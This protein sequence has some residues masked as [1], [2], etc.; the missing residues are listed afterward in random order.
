MTDFARKMHCEAEAMATDMAKAMNAASPNGWSP[1]VGAGTNVKPFYSPYANFDPEVCDTVVIGVNPSGNPRKPDSI[2]ATYLDDLNKPRGEYN[3]YL[4]E[5]WARLNE[6]GI[7]GLQQGVKAVFRTLYE[8]AT[9]EQK[10]RNA[11]SFNVCPLRTNESQHIPI[12]VWKA[13]VNWC[14]KVLEYLNPKRIICFAVFTPDGKP[15]DRSP[16]HA[17]DCKYQIKPDFCADVERARD[18]FPAFV[19]AGETRS[20][21]FA[22]CEVIGVPHLSYHHC[23]NQVY[24]ALEKYLAQP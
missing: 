7:A 11:A 8:P 23:N 13:S 20:D 6:P 3:A 21:A 15:A 22:G 16:W 4:D 1:R 10:L 17:I 9:R 2:E 18:P 19:M 12:A 24:E 14:R 5:T